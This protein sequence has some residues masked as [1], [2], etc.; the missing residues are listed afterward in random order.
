MSRELTDDSVGST[1]AVRAVSDRVTVSREHVS[2][3]DLSPLVPS[4]DVVYLDVQ[5]YY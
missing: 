4:R 2:G 5:T 1:R 3:P